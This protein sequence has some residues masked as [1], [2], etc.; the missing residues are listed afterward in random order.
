MVAAR[1]L[2]QEE[3]PDFAAAVLARLPRFK[4]WNRRFLASMLAGMGPQV[5]VTLRSGLADPSAEAATRAV[6]A[7]ALHLQGDVLAGDVAVDILGGTTDRELLISSL[8]LLREVGRPDHAPAV[9]A[10][11]SSADPVIRAQALLTLGTLGEKEDLPTLRDGLGDS[12]PWA[13]L[14][15]ARGLLEASGTT[16]LAE[17]A[18]A[19]GAGAAVARQVL[20]EG[21]A[22]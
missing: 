1:A 16:V 19:D 12:S 2:A 17:V 4:G 20:S 11:C 9:R 21:G 8:R 22:R 10:Q 6:L 18:A 13:A 7:E 15:A 14:N 5:S 3:S